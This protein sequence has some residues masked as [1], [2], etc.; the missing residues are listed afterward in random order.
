MLLDYKDPI[1]V[2]SNVIESDEEE[3]IQI[4]DKRKNQT[5]SEYDSEYIDGRV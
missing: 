2:K 1:M 3:T 4:L 5:I